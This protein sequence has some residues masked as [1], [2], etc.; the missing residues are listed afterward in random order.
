MFCLP[1]T[2]DARALVAPTEVTVAVAVTEVEPLARVTE[3]LLKEQFGRSTAPL[4]ELV[5]T[6][7]S[8]TVP[9]YAVVVLTVTVE[10][11]GDPAATAAGVVAASAKSDCVS[12]GEL[13]P[14]VAPVPWA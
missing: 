6:Q 3:D 13:D 2:G 14:E 12:V 10:V 7:L 1:L 5:K 9:E 4:G 11:A 8:A